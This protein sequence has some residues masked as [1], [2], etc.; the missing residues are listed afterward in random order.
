[1]KN[2]IQHQLADEGPGT[3]D[4]RLG[5]VGN[6]DAGKRTGKPERVSAALSGG[7]AVIVVGRELNLDSWMKTVQE[8]LAKARRAKSYGLTLEA[9]ERMLQDISRG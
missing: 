4:Q 9:F 3:G 1:M 7:R 8:A 5:S 2:E 6:G